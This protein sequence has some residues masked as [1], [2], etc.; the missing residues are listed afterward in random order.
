MY[1]HQKMTMPALHGNGPRNL[2]VIIRKPR[3]PK[4]SMTFSSFKDAMTYLKKEQLKELN[5]DETDI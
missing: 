3:A 4:S 1:M 5:K 2:A